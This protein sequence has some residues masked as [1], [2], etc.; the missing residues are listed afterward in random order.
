MFIKRGNTKWTHILLLFMEGAT[1][2]FWLPSACKAIRFLFHFFFF[3]H[4]KL[5]MYKLCFLREKKK[6]KRMPWQMAAFLWRYIFSFSLEKLKCL[7]RRKDFR[8]IAWIHELFNSAKH[9]L[10]TKHYTLVV[11]SNG[12][13]ELYMQ[14]CTRSTQTPRIQFIFVI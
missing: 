8:A 6:R 4:L 11:N 14:K 9:R 13:T 10:L 7:V 5:Y 1:Y 3:F 12:S 2:G